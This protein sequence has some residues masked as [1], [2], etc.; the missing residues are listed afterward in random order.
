MLVAVGVPAQIAPQPSRCPGLRWLAAPKC[1]RPGTQPVAVSSTQTPDRI[2]KVDT[3]FGS[4]MWNRS[5]VS[6]SATILCD[7]CKIH[8]LSK[9]KQNPRKANTR[10]QKTNGFNM[11]PVCLG[12]W[13]LACRCSVC[14]GFRSYKSQNLKSPKHQCLSLFLFGAESFR[15]GC[16]VGLSVFK[17][18]EDLKLKLCGS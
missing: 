10:R 13:F 7:I 16:S 2:Q 11:F 8:S 1:H 9:N 3:L 18:S 17:G 6:R 14:F 15:S 5:L 12:L 4:P